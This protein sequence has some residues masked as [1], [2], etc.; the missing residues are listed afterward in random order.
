MKKGKKK[1]RERV[2]CAPPPLLTHTRT[3]THTLPNHRVRA[4]P[5]KVRFVGPILAGNTTEPIPAELQVRG[6]ERE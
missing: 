1:R 6:G 5:D 4:V 3:H 2:G